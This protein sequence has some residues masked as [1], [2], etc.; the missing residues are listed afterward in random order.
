MVAANYPVTVVNNVNTQIIPLRKGNNLFS[1]YL[2]PTNAKVDIVMQALVAQ[3]ALYK[4]Q[5]EAGN[6]YQYWGTYGGWINKIGSIAET[7][8]YNIK[9]N[10]NCTLQITGQMIVLPLAIPL[11]KGWNIIS[12]P[13]KDQVNAMY[14]IQSLIDQNRLVK[15]QDELG[16]SIQY[17]KGN[18]WVNNIGNLQSWSGI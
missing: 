3:N 7:E 6:S 16:N 11:K 5:D 12:Y 10:F 13:R 8:G 2:I 1:T 4:V 17:I 14:I 15:V 18:G 9:V